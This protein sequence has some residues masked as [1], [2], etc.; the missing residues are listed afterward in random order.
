MCEMTYCVHPHKG[1]YTQRD[2]VCIARTY[3]TASTNVYIITMQA[4][5][6]DVLD[7]DAVYHKGVARQGRGLRRALV[8]QASQRLNSNSV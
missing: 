4:W 3:C 8:K 7:D 6:P 1:K 2:G 5:R